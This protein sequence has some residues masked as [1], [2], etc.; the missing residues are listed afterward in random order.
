MSDRDWAKPSRVMLVEDH[1]SFRQALTFFLN[2]EPDFTVVAEAD[3][4]A[5][6]RAVLETIDL[7]IVDLALPDGNGADL[8]EDIRRANPGVTVLILSATLDEVNIVRVVDA[9]ASGVVDK[10]AGVNEIVQEARLVRAGAAMPRQ[11]EVVEMLRTIASHGGQDHE[12]RSDARLTARETE[13]LRALVEGLDNEGV[14]EKLGI[15]LEKEQNHLV[16]ILEKLEARS[17]LQALA[18]AA[19]R[20]IIEFP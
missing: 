14:A 17:G 4:L 10:M 12:V 1:H 20:G 13:V 15:T 19:R 9:G 2:L 5:K 18:I 7:A 8:I 11:T 3:S 6:A 16:S